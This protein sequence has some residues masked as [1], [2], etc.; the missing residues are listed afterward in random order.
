VYCIDGAK[1][2]AL[3]VATVVNLGSDAVGLMPQPAPVDTKTLADNKVV[4][5]LGTDKAT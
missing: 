1:A 2:E 4:V 3:A 5:L